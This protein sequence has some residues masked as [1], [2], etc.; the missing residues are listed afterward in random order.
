MNNFGINFQNTYTSL[1]NIFY[2]KQVPN[3]NV[4]KPKFAVFNHTL[5]EELGLDADALFKRPDI[6]AGA[7]VPPGADP[8]A[9]AYAGYQFGHF[10]MLGDGRAVLLGEH[11][12]PNGKIVDIQ[13]KGSG[14]TP[15]SRGGDGRAALAPMLREFLFSEVMF[16]LGIPT[17]RTLAVVMTG[18]TVMRQKPMKGAVLTRIAASHIRVG[19]FNFAAAYADEDELRALADYAIR[20]HYPDLEGDYIGFLRAVA[21]RQAELIANW[22][23]RGFIHGVMNTDNVSICGETIDYGPC[24]FMDSYGLDTVYSSIDTAG[25][26]AY[27]KQPAIG[28]WNLAR[29]AES[30]RPL[31]PS[32][33]G[34]AKQVVDGVFEAY[35]DRFG[36]T[37][38]RL[39]REKGAAFVP[40]N[41]YVEEALAAAEHGDFAPFNALLDAVRNPY[42]TSSF[43]NFPLKN[44]TDYK[45]FCGT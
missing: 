6:F 7:T 32:S 26:Y 44:Q 17:T 21:E 29:L 23:H 8:I 3:I 38:A 42:A 31:I 33:I 11:I 12:C 4:T 25:R 19:T 36:N 37:L 1:S 27:G 28:A 41:N 20:R 2:T 30:M 35:W 13:L 16:Y 24:A 43:L 34:N 10:T 39:Y 9:Q 15:Y 40:R 45:T 18:E 5:A 14:I 22:I